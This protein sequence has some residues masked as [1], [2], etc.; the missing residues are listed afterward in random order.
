MSTSPI[1]SSKT[2]QVAIETTPTPLALTGAVSDTAE[3]TN[4]A[5]LDRLNAGSSGRFGY[6]LKSNHKEYNLH[7][8]YNKDND[9]VTVTT[10]DGY[11]V[12]FTNEHERVLVTDPQGQVTDIW[13]DP[14]VY[15][16]DGDKWDFHQQVTFNFGKNKMTIEVGRRADSDLTFVE[17]A[18]IISGTERFSM[19]GIKDNKISL[20]KWSNT[21]GRK[22]DNAQADGLNYYLH[23]ETGKKF[24]WKK[25]KP[26]VTAK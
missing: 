5:E 12:E 11:T 21:D 3:I 16:S 14:H 9:H 6:L 24:S 22:Y 17:N 25:S 19:G 1:D 10:R 15:E 4:Q 23:D 26:A 13:G 2:T 7:A 8:N 20:Q 18:T